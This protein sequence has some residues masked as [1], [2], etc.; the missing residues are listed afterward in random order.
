MR[1]VVLSALLPLALVAACDAPDQLNFAFEGTALPEAPSPIP[2]DSVL[3][4]SRGVLYITR[5]TTTPCFSDGLTARGRLDS[6]MLTLTV[7]RIAASPCPDEED[8]FFRYQAFFS[9]L[10]AGTYQV[11]VLEQIEGTPMVVKDTSVV[12]R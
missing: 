4:P 7:Q 11:Q 6:G 2:A 12:V 3:S 5:T 10:R 8:R 1:K 9:S